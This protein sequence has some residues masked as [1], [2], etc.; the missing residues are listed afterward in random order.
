MDCLANNIENIPILI[1]NENNIN[2]ELRDDEQFAHLSNVSTHV[3]TPINYNEPND[4]VRNV[5]LVDYS[6]SDSDEAVNSNQPI[7]ERR[8]RFDSDYSFHENKDSDFYFSSSDS[9]VV[10]EQTNDVVGNTGIKKPKKLNTKHLKKREKILGR[11]KSVQENPCKSTVCQHG[12]TKQ[13]TEQQRHDIF[14][15]YWGLGSH[16]KQREWL[17]SCLKEVAI[18]RRRTY[19]ECSRRKRTFRYYISWNAREVEVCQQFL[20]KT[21]NISQMTIRYTR[22]NVINE[23]FVKPDQRGKHDPPHKTKPDAKRCV[24]EYIKELPAVP[25]HYCRSSS[26]KKYL[27]NELR[28]MLK[29]MYH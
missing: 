15:Y 3:L 22:D 6:S 4:L 25:S 19:T 20:L 26:S 7:I 16:Q 21:L 29:P 9:E 10:V 24:Q 1:D 27:P 18:K 8:K 13:F 2:I 17:L 28:K 12:C 11:G 5:K 23:K 14:E